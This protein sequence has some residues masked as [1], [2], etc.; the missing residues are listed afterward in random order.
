[1]PGKRYTNKEIIGRLDKIEKKPNAS[2]N[3]T[4]EYGVYVIG[5]S[6]IVI[7]VSMLLLNFVS[8]IEAISIVITGFIMIGIVFFYL[9]YEVFKSRKK[10]D[11]H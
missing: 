6:L 9:L 4:I 7:G 5:I 3:I 11:N 1:M 2:S 8:P 10:S